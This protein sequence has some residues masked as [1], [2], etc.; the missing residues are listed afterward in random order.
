V[1]GSG[2]S[3]IQIDMSRKDFIYLSVF[4]SLL[5][6]AFTDAAD[7]LQIYSQNPH[8]F[9]DSSGTPFFFLGDTATR[10][11]HMLTREDMDLYFRTR[12]SQGF[13]VILAS[14]FRGHTAEYPKPNAYGEWP[15]INNDITR[16]NIH[17]GYDY[18]DHIDY[19]ID[20]ADA[21]G[22]KIA[23]T[24]FAVGWTESGL[25]D[26]GFRFLNVS[27]AYTYGRW[28]GQ[29]YANRSN[30]IWVLG[31]DNP[32]NTAGEDTIWQEMGR[33]IK[34]GAGSQALITFH[35]SI[36]WPNPGPGSSSR[37][38]HDASWLD[39]NMVQARLEHVHS[40]I[41]ADYGYSPAKPTGVGE[42]PYDEPRKAAYWSYLAGGYYI[43][44]NATI[45]GFGDTGDW[46]AALNSPGARHMSILKSF[47]TSLAWWKYVPDQSVFTFGQGSGSTLNA[48]A[49]SSDRDSMLVYLASQTTVGINMGK[50]TA[51]SSVY[52]KWFNPATGEYLAVGTFPASGSKEFTTPPGWEDAVLYLSATAAPPSLPPP[53]PFP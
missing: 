26:G 5:T 14:A 9:A 49:L 52:A 47:F 29:R 7:R 34:D 17:S 50:I 40:G 28:I 30:I 10:M 1:N 12:A 25:H 53:R 43:S 2:S 18:W 42:G 11:N 38:F 21:Y 8:L 4:F 20:T 51:G 48:A 24:A 22:L 15:F 13:T 44:G 45:W 27:N 3:G 16:P 39:F 19:M 6:P 41:E 36:E 23:L 32:V 37:W 35:T 46:K 33:G 31:W